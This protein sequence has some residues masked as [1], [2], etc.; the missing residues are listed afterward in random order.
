MSASMKGTIMIE[1]KQVVI[2]NPNKLLWPQQRITKAIYLQKLSALSPYLLRYCK[3]RHL[4]T[5]RYPDGVEGKS[6]YQKNCP[7]P[8][9][10]Y[11]HTAMLDNIDYV[12]LDTLPTLFWL[13]N[14]ACL[15][16]HPS[17]HYIDDILPAEWVIDLDPTLEEEPRIMEAAYLIGELLDTL[18]IQAIPKTSGATG[19]QIYVPIVRG[20]TFD[21]LR[22]IG[23]FI[24][25]YMVKKYPQLF[26]IER[27]KKNRG[28]LI[29]IDYLQHY[30][31]KTLSAPYT[32]R[33][34]TLAT[35]STPLK[36]EEL[37]MGISARDFHLLNIEER[38]SHYGDLIEQVP[39]Q[40]LGHIVEHLK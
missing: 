7:D 17:F 6:F 8:K 25:E 31:G 2:S 40:S 37:R 13:G 10:D 22:K 38:I 3:G 23:H 28:D 11:V 32:P 18:N 9:P 29:Y 1:G 26:T 30:Y 33:A 21:E 35:V 16:F 27:M 5:I 12:N 24:G 19:I 34:R 15:E 14:L 39:L 4:T 20:I 36:W